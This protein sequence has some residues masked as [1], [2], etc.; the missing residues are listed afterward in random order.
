MSIEMSTT[1]AG[2][3]IA[4][5]RLLRAALRL[6]AG[7][8]AAAGVAYIAA[9]GPLSDWLG[10]PNELLLIT[11]AFLVAWGAALA[12]LATR[13]SVAP[14][15]IRAVIALNAAWV[16]DS[17]LLLAVDGFSP[18]LAGQVMVAY[19]AVAVIGFAALQY[20]GLKRSS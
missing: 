19:Q 20:L 10:L 11:G 3:R 6:D 13:A 16:A 2:T 15:A 1:A 14:A 5:S 12:R 18:S 7:V 8:S 9:V 17:F 4:P